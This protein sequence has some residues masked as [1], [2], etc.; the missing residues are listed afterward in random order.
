MALIY[1]LDLIRYINTFDLEGTQRLR[2]I[3]APGTPPANSLYF[4]AADKFGVSN[5][6]WISDAGITCDLQL[7]AAHTILSATHTD[8]LAGTVVLGDVIYGNSTPAWTRLAGQIT[9]TRK[10]LRQT[11]TGTVSAVP[12]WDTI[13]AA[14]VPGSALTRTDDTNVTLTLGGTPTTALLVAASLTLGWTG[15]LAVT[16]CGTGQSTVA[17]YNALLDHGALLGLTD[18]DHTQYRLERAD[19]SHKSTGLQAG[20]LDHGLALTGL[21][22][23][24]HTQY[25]LAAGTRALPGNWDV[26]SFEVR[27]QTFQSDVVTGTAPLIV[28]STTLVTNLNADLL[29]SQSGAFYLDLANFTGTNWTDLTDGGATTL[30]SHAGA[31][32]HTIRENGTDQTARTG[33]NFIDA[34]AG[35]GLITDDAVGDE[36]EVNLSLYRLEAQDHSHQSTGLQAGTLDHGLALTGLTDDDHTQYVIRSI[37]TTRGDLFTRDASVVVRLAVGSTAGLFLRSDGTDPS[38]TSDQAARTDAT[39]NRFRYLNMA[40]KVTRGTNQT[41]SNDTTTDVAWT[42]ENINTHAIHDTA[43]D[44][45]RLTA[46]I[47]G[48]YEVSGIGRFQTNGTG[49]RVFRIR[50]NGTSTIASQ[51]FAGNVSIELASCLTTLVH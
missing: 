30:H 36:T 13:L 6:Y 12:V 35:A 21:T 34:D 49:S 29:D 18:D 14:D 41:I 38:W 50:L 11:G 3:T 43:T 4:Y 47:A 42:S 44:N 37:L 20:T 32:A 16:R 26:G 9:T 39:N 17:G 48:I 7:A 28:A 25:L 22:D 10:F 19:H 5:L 51:E 27:A 33:L 31:S 24:D 45:S 40:C 46:P 23:D 8:S 2:E 15:T 1:Y